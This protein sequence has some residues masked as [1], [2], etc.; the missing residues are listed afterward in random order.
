MASSRRE[1][2][3][4]HEL[5]HA[6]RTLL[7]L[8]EATVRTGDHALAGQAFERLAGVT[9]AAGTGYACG[10]LAMAEAQLRK[11][12]EAEALYREAIERFEHERIPIR[13]GAAACCTG[14][15]RAAEAGPRTRAISSGP[16]TSSCPAAA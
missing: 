13:W 5:S 4:A 15:R 16:P 8:V 14:R 7:E 1:L 2:P 9:R 3:Y 11:G 10:V 12:E 6:M